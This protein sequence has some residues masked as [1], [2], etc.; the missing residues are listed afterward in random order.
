MCGR[1]CRLWYHSSIMD[2]RDFLKA[3]VA[4]GGLSLLGGPGAVAAVKHSRQKKRNGDYAL[5]SCGLSKVGD[6][7]NFLYRMNLSSRAIDMLPIDLHMA[8][9]ILKTS[10]QSDVAYVIERNGGKIA[11]IS[12]SGFKVRRTFSLE[13]MHFYGHGAYHAETNSL[14]LTVS[15]ETPQEAA[16]DRIVALNLSSWTITRTFETGT[17]GMG[18]HDIRLLRD[19][20]SALVVLQGAAQNGTRVGGGV[21]M[22]DLKEN[23]V[24]KRWSTS[25]EEG[26]PVHLSPMR[27]EDRVFVTMEKKHRKDDVPPEVAGGATKGSNDYYRLMAGGFD[28]DPSSVGSLSL[29]S[30]KIEYLKPS[31][32]DSSQRGPFNFFWSEDP[33]LSNFVVVDFIFG[34]ALW[35]WDISKNEPVSHRVFPGKKS[36]ACMHPD[37]KSILAISDTGVGYVLEIP[38]LSIKSEFKTTIPPATHPLV[39]RLV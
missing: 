18:P 11:E 33:S 17:V 38:S 10:P 21:V 19:S 13:G 35:V 6:K 8:H 20:K 9:S 16:K 15:G 37:G 12:L 2:R 28:Q 26:V 25:D 39:S 22:L 3:F 23:R 5:F 1:D 7:K 32:V 4:A 31:V 24:V 36:S 29:A 27:S 30:G 14:L 34:P